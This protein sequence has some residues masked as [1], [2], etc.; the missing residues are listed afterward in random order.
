VKCPQLDDL[1]PPPPGATGWPWTEDTAGHSASD[2]IVEDWPRI[3]IVTPSFNQG[4]F[5]EETIRSVL[6]QGYPDIEYFVIDGGSTDETVSIIEKYAPW[7]AHWESQP[8]RGQSHAINKGLNRSSG[9]IVAYIK[10]RTDATISP[11]IDDRTV[12][13]DTAPTNIADIY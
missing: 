3:S 12:Q 4:H 8:D 6:L 11:V 5:I 10:S 9:E 1:P 13:L 2:N 7:L